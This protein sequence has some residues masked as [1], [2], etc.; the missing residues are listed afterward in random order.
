MSEKR[1][2]SK[3]EPDIM[4][5]LCTKRLDWCVLLVL[6]GEGQEI[7][8][9]ENSGIAQWN[10]AIQNSTIQWDV[11]C[12]NKLDSVFPGKRILNV[13]NRNALN[14]SQSLRTHLAGD[15]STFA[16]ALISCDIS[17]AKE[18]ARKVKSSGFPMY[19]TRNLETAK[20]YLRQ[21]Y[22][23]E[24]TK[25]YGMIASSKG[26]VLRRHGM[27]NSFQG[28]VGMFYVGKW[29]NADAD[30]RR[31]CCALSSVATEFSCQG[32]E[33]DMPLIGWDNDMQWDGRKW[34]KY[35]ISEPDDSD[36]NTYRKNSY[37]VLL[38]RGRDGFVIFVPDEESL[39]SVYYLL[40]DVGVEEL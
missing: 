27:D 23:G 19:V 22:Q 6:V 7:H 24:P 37:R 11:L 14:L 35:K 9:G 36:A 21:R 3:S 32:L 8:N 31:S 38:T 20:E 18:Y 17:K 29:F 28:S 13:S 10:T 12:P 25:R 40:T 4:I 30:D 34:K 26:N 15:V 39:D 1:N 33:M 5:E 16:N 2:T